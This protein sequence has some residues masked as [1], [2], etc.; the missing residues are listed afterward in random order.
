VERLET[1]RGSVCPVLCPPGALCPPSALCPPVGRHVAFVAGRR[2]GEEGRAAP[3]RVGEVGRRAE[4]VGPG[5]EE[6]GEEWGIGL[7]PGDGRGMG[8]WR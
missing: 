5:F 1:G 6:G 8:N 4:P 3:S 2:A 7:G